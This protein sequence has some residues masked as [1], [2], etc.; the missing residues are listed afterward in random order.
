MLTSAMLPALLWIGQVPMYPLAAPMPP[1]PQPDYA[2]PVREFAE[3]VVPADPVIVCV[4]RPAT[5]PYDKVTVDDAARRVMQV[6][7][8]TRLREAEYLGQLGPPQ[9]AE[10]RLVPARPPTPAERQQRRAIEEAV[11]RHWELFE[12]RLYEVRMFEHQPQECQ[13]AARRAAGAW[14]ALLGLILRFPDPLPADLA[15]ELGE[16][17]ALV[18]VLRAAGS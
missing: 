9:R 5:V 13:L 16:V 17:D 4:H 3:V 7:K 10:R 2:L 1:G 14:D 6:I 8:L 18:G 12:A 15:D 11:S